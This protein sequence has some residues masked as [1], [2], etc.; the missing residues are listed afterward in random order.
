MA[1]QLS[2]CE[3]ELIGAIREVAAEYSLPKLNFVVAEVNSADGPI[4]TLD[5]LDHDNVVHL[6]LTMDSLSQKVLS[7]LVEKIDA[8]FERYEGSRDIISCNMMF[9]SSLPAPCVVSVQ[10]APRANLHL[11]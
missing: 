11:V 6:S 10:Y 2:L 5:P 1:T 8:I 3:A 4:Y 7:A 9:D